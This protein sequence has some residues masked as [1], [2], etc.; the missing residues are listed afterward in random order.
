MTRNKAS[1]GDR[2]QAEL[3]QI[4][5]DGESAALNMKQIWKICGGHGTG[6]GQFFFSILKNRN[7]KECS[8]CCATAII[9]HASKIML[10]ILQVRLQQFV[11]KNFQMCKLH[12]EKPEESE[13]QMP[14]SVGS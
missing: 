10:K 7:G 6:N 9:S 11:N 12:L 5:K 2:I 1:G 4:V 13:I 3:F 14:T 8:D